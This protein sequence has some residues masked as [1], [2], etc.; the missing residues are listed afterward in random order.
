MTHDDAQTGL[1]LIKVRDAQGSERRNAPAKPSS[2][3]ARSRFPAK[4]SG[5]AATMALIRS[6]SAGALRTLALPN[7]RRIPRKVALTP[8]ES[9]GVSRF[10]SL[11]A[12]RIAAMRRARVEGLVPDPACAAIKAATVSGSAGNA[13]A[14]LVWHHSEKIRKSVP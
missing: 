6:A 8:S 13:A 7:V 9:V 2:T 4:V 11:C 5:E 12:W 3:S 14:P 10:A 1:R